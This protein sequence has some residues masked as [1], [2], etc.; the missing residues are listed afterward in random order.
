MIPQGWFA[1]HMGLGRGVG[2]R[3]LRAGAIVYLLGAICPIAVSHANEVICEPVPQDLAQVAYFGPD[4][5][6]FIRVEL[7]IPREYEGLKFQSLELS[8]EPTQDGI[9]RA[10]IRS[11]VATRN[12]YERI[13]ASFQMSIQRNS[14]V[15]L[16]AVYFDHCVSH[17]LIEIDPRRGSVLDRNL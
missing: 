3:R 17:L 7:G 4:E 14:S 9:G 6:G 10:G 8:I 11:N 16:R 12:F 15:T 1:E 2:L 5:R 13:T